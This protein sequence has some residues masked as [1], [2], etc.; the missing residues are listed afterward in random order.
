MGWRERVSWAHHS[1]RHAPIRFPQNAPLLNTHSLFSVALSVSF[2]PR[3]SDFP[4]SEC[5]TPPPHVAAEQPIY[6]YAGDPP[7]ICSLA[8]KRADQRPAHYLAFHKETILW[9]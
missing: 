8:S 3:I 6:I 4:H 1:P 2:A 9:S 5:R 7:S